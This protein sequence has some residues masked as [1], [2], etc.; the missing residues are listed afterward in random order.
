MNKV[1]ERVRDLQQEPAKTTHTHEKTIPQGLHML[2]LS[3]T[4]Y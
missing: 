1:H 4:D 2:R 3:N